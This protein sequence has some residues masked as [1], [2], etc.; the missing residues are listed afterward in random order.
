MWSGGLAADAIL[1]GGDGETTA[2]RYRDAVENAIWPELR[3]AGRI[4]FLF[5]CMPRW[6]HRLL[7]RLPRGVLQYA[8][9]LAGEESYR[10]LVRHVTERIERQ[11]SRWALARLG[12]G[13]DAGRA[14]AEKS[15]EKRHEQ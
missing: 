4:G 8:G 5:H 10:G 6:W 1:A 12:L 2:R 15:G 11:G 13:R 14:R 9:V 3:A 7:S